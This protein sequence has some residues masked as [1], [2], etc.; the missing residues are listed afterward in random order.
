MLISNRQILKTRLFTVF[1]W[2]ENILKPELFENVNVTII[3][4]FPDR[5]FI[6]Y[7]SSMT[8]DCCVFK[9]LRLGVTKKRCVFCEKSPFFNSSEKRKNERRIE[10]TTRSRVVLTNFEVFGNAVK[11]SRECL[12]A[13]VFD[14]SSKSKLKL[15]KNGEKKT[16]VKIYTS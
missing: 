10:N 4:D 6:K 5:V 8:G 9:F 15:R 16:V 13:G 2:T 7:K 14:I 11:H 3:I 1:V 12:I